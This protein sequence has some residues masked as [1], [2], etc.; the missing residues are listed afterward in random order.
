MAKVEFSCASEDA[1]NVIGVR[2][3][4]TLTFS[5]EI[6]TCHTVDMRTP[7]SYQSV[8]T[9]GIVTVTV[10]REHGFTY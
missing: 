10:L 2:S 7:W 9:T 5:Y 4:F 1:T 8:C 3:M 6:T